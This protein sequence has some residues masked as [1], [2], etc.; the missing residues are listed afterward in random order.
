WDTEENWSRL[1]RFLSSLGR[2]LDD[3]ATV[4]S[5]HLHPDH[6]GLTRRI[7]DHTGTPAIMHRVEIEAFHSDRPRANLDVDEERLTTWGVPEEQH[8][9]LS[10]PLDLGVLPT[11]PSGLRPIE[12][13]ELLP[14]PGRRIEAV[15]T[16]GHTSGHLCFREVDERL[17]FTGDHVL[18]TINPGLGLG[19]RVRTNP[20][21][22]YL[23]ALE[24]IAEH[25]DHEI[26]PG[27]EAPFRGLAIRCASAAEHHLRR[28]REVRDLMASHPGLSVWD[29]ARRLRWRRG[30]D[31]LR[32]Y[33]AVSALAQTQLHM[34]FV[35]AP[36]AAR[37][38]DRK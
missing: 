11:L 25:D 13:G 35:A 34:E 19:G 2:T 17:L 6:L 3:V 29:T 32:D 12:D 24:R 21:L 37:Y 16:P 1:T 4:T 28:A 36:E 9:R 31:A 20:V 30:W 8:G 26:L 22:D 38:L 33:H 18:P 23:G 14:I 10:G 7:A 15:W 5:T 27:H